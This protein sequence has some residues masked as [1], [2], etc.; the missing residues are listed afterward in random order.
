VYLHTN[1]SKLILSKIFRLYNILHSFSTQPYISTVI[2]CIHSGHIM[3][4]YFDR[5]TVIFRPIENIFK[6]Q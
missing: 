2:L 3:A 5:K 4:T 1:K 6:V